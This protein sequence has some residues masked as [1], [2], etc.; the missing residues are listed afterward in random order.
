MDFTNDATRIASNISVKLRRLWERR[1]PL[2][3]E[4]D[5]PYREEFAARTAAPGDMTRRD[6]LKKTAPAVVAP[7]LLQNINPA[8][9]LQQG[10]GAAMNAVKGFL[11]GP[12]EA[13]AKAIGNHRSVWGDMVGQIG[14]NFGRFAEIGGRYGLEVNFSEEGKGGYEK[15]WF[16]EDNGVLRK[17][18][19]TGGG[20][21]GISVTDELDGTPIKDVP[22]N[23]LDWYY[24]NISYFMDPTGEGNLPKG[25]AAIRE[26]KK[27]WKELDPN[28]DYDGNDPTKQLFQSEFSKYIP[29]SGAVIRQSVHESDLTRAE[30]TEHYRWSKEDME[31]YTPEE[32]Q[33]IV[34]DEIRHRQEEQDKWEREYKESLR[35]QEEKRQKKR[36][37]MNQQQ[38]ERPSYNQTHGP[39]DWEPGDESKWASRVIGGSVRFT[40]DYTRLAVK[41]PKNEKQ[42]QKASQLLKIPVEQVIAALDQVDPQEKFTPWLLTQ[43]TSGKIRLP[44]DGHRVGQALA[45]FIQKNNVLPEKDINKYVTVNSLE[46]A[47]E[48]VA[49]V[50][51]KRQKGFQ[52]N[53]V[54]LPGVTKINEIGTNSLWKV[55]DATS[56]AKMGLGTKWCTREDYPNC[57]AKTY[58][59]K[60][61]RIYVISENH[62]PKIQFTPDLSQVMDI[63][64]QYTNISSYYDLLKPLEKLYTKNAKRAYSFIKHVSQK[65]TPE[66][67]PILLTDPEVALNYLFYYKKAPW[68]ELAEIVKDSPWKAAEY[69]SSLQTRWPEVEPLIL[70]NSS[71]AIGYAEKALK[72]RWPQ[73]ESLLLKKATPEKALD[74]TVNV[75]QT[76]WPELEERLIKDQD[77]RNIVLYAYYVNRGRWPEIENGLMKECDKT[78]AYDD[79]IKYA[80][81]VIKGRWPHLEARLLKT[82]STN[83]SWYCFL[84][85]LT[86]IKAPF[87]EFEPCIKKN[88][89]FWKR[90]QEEILKIPPV[91]K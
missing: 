88:S 49:Q 69:A 55:T 41:M 16:V 32:R 85:V 4:S 61:K 37:E 82:Q 44:E 62:R 71:A 26:L 3:I 34:N 15:T 18:A 20:Y 35:K 5:N 67:E 79:A 86:V 87:P 23:L 6:F 40:H 48:A 38:K 7:S 70:K 84:Y 47:I 36:D 31:K 50:L 29:D 2:G 24:T 78:G 43:W 68:P 90:Y 42:V 45:Q 10:A 59:D 76:P 14:Y 21:R 12:L 46:E 53:P 28:G 33:K 27:R 13:I 30:G 74:Y 81:S 63:N 57:A 73:L 80:S 52:V 91:R 11:G 64:D 65:Q 75:L 58:L 51:P 8:Q 66:F 39:F 72:A 25:P 17:V 19:N 60:Y 54:T 22:K 77:Y 83:S 56:L 1:D 9:A 89:I